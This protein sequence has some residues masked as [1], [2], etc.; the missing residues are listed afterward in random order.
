MFNEQQVW[1]RHHT[2]VDVCAFGQ[3][4]EKPC[5]SPAVIPTFQ[6]SKLRLQEW[7]GGL[8]KVNG[9]RRVLIGLQK[10]WQPWGSNVFISAASPLVAGCVCAS[11]EAVHCKAHMI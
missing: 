1:A 7:G 2:D 9:S 8:A 5:E 6:M 4:S 11:L 3:A 10:F